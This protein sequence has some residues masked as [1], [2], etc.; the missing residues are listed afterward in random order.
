MAQHVGADGFDVAG[1]HVAAALQ[2]GPRF[3]S[4][5][6]RDGGARARAELDHRTQVGELVVLR[7]AGGEDDVDDVVAHFFIHV[8]RVHDGAGGHDLLEFDDTL[9]VEVR[10]RE[11]HGVEDAALFFEARIADDDLQHEA[12]NLRFG[13]RVGAFLIDWIFCR[14][15]EEGR[16]EFV[17]FATE[18][19][20][21]LLHR[22]EQCG[23]H[24][25][26]GAID[27]IGEHEVGENGA[28][29]GVIF[30]VAGIVDE[31]AD[32]V[33]WQQVGRKLNTAE[34]RVNR[35]CERADG[36][37]FC[38]AGHAFEEDVSIRQQADEQAV[39]EMLLADDDFADDFA[40][41]GDPCGCLAHLGV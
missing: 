34:C 41:L 36:E 16:W 2:Q 29:G 11:S 9:D 28:F 14:E 21:P 5:C 25:C 37:R 23:L 6:E 31:R 19:D 40:E 13:Q 4:E 7:V 39:N 1:C 8:E 12:I 15:D 33:R 3:R 27:F 30:S 18:R 35:R 22:F 17:R 10:L 38:E 32:D 20:L 26:G 24:F